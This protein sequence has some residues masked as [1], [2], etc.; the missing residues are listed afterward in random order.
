E[1]RVGPDADLSHPDRPA[2]RLDHERLL[3]LA[4]AH[5]RE[6]GAARRVDP[7]GGIPPR[8]APDGLA[9][10]RRLRGHSLLDL[11]V[12]VDLLADPDDGLIRTDLPTHP[13]RA[14][15]HLR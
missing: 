1:Y 5:R 9:R 12:R 11:L 15:V 10:D 8:A 14:A 4:A 3:R 2:D 7:L 6:C 13:V